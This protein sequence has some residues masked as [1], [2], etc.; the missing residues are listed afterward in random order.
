MEA[1]MENLEQMQAV[2]A[3]HFVPYHSLLPEP[4]GVTHAAQDAEKA[5]EGPTWWEWESKRSE[6]GGKEGRK[7]LSNIL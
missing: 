2:P 6:A 4:L 3:A 1:A 7:G 5:A